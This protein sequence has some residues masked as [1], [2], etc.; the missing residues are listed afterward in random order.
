MWKVEYPPNDQ[1]CNKGSSVWVWINV[2]HCEN[3]MNGTQM[4]QVWQLN[5]GFCYAVLAEYHL[6]ET[7]DNGRS[8]AASK[9]RAV[10]CKVRM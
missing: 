4:L 2:K 5:L 10:V 9:V 6:W 7:K 3:K 1:I 8:T